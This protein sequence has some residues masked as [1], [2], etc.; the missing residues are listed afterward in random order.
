MIIGISGGSGAGKSTLSRKLLEL[1]PN[2]LLVIVDNYM[3][4]I[5][6]KMEKQIFEKIGIEKDNPNISSINYYFANYENVKTWISTIERD[7]INRIK[8]EIENNGKMKQYILVDWCFLPLSDFFKK[9]D[10]TVYVASD[11]DKRE[12]RLTERFLNKDKWIHN[13]LDS[14]SLS[15]Y[16]P[17]I[18]KNRI[19]Y[20]NLI[21]YGFE[22]DYYINNNSTIE[23]F[24]NN[25][26]QLS[27]KILI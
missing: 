8:Q 14:I 23:D 15:S 5:T 4:E 3:R 11:D 20:T 26:N 19:K 22:F 25:I 9:C 10:Y 16:K 2:S 24:Y 12:K 13:N 6:R 17:D 21:N 1:L 18:F 7:V 27:N